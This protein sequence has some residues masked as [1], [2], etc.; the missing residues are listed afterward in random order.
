ME[1]TRV[2]INLELDVDGESLSGHARDGH[3][4]QRD[5]RGWLGLVGAIDALL[6]QDTDPQEDSQ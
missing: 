3:G 6:D 1:S 2:T 5:F 4:T